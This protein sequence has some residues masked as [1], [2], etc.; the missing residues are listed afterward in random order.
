MI[1][2]INWELI[3]DNDNI[4]EGIENVRKILK[5][6]IER[7]KIVCVEGFCICLKLL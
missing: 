7:D 1:K 4:K 6:N 5:W 3:E 2:K